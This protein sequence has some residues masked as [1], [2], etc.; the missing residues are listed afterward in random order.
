GEGKVGT[1]AHYPY[2]IFLSAKVRQLTPAG[3][4]PLEDFMLPNY[5][6]LLSEL[7][8]ELGEDQVAKIPENERANAVRRLLTTQ[9][10]LLLIDNLGSV[11]ITCDGCKNTLVFRIFSRGFTRYRDT[12]IIWK[13]SPKPS[14][15]GCSSF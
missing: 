15:T 4:Q 11:P 7:A 13:H 12:T 2:K 8:R 10:A 6:A 3:E 9:R 14:V 5:M 1:R